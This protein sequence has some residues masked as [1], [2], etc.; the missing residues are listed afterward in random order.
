MLGLV[1]VG[2]CEFSDE[3]SLLQEHAQARPRKQKWPDISKIVDE[4]KDAAQNLNDTVHNKLDQ[5]AEATATAIQSV[6]NT[7]REGLVTILHK[8]DAFEDNV[9]RAVTTLVQGV[10]NNPD[11]HTLMVAANQTLDSFGVALEPIASALNVSIGTLRG[12][13]SA[14]GYHDLSE[15]VSA[16]LSKAVSAINEA[17]LTKTRLKQKVGE[18][19]VKVNKSAGNLSSEIDRD[20]EYMHNQLHSL[21]EQV[22]G[23]FVNKTL[24]GYEKLETRFRESVESILPEK[25]LKQVVESLLSINPVVKEVTD[26]VVD[27]IQKLETGFDEAVADIHENVPGSAHGA[28]GFSILALVVS[29]CTSSIM[30]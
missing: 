2:H 10:Q 15:D 6:V 8:A 13:L 14:S 5:A 3:L 27:P 25:Q 4:V 9:Q 21:V 23:T 12:V 1:S 16:L 11:L 18:L 7:L 20:L 30:F 17:N 19:G 28:A 26:H 29:I 22:N 24:E